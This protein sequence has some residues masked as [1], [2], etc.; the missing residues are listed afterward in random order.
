MG[1]LK[2]TGAVS[3]LYAAYMYGALTALCK[4]ANNGEPSTGRQVSEIMA[5]KV[6]QTS[7]QLTYFSAALHT[8][9]RIHTHTHMWFVASIHKFQ[10]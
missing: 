1:N 9:A 2:P 5:I 4:T 3:Q 6:M 7:L 10:S 8:H